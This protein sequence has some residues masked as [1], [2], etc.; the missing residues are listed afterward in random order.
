MINKPPIYIPIKHICSL[1]NKYYWNDWDPYEFVGEIN[2]DLVDQLS[3]LSYRAVVT[4]AIGCTEWVIWRFRDKLKDETPY[5]YIEACWLYNITDK[6]E[7]PPELED[8][9]W[10]GEVRGAVN[11]ALSTV[12][13]SIYSIEDECPE[14]EAAYADK[15]AL[16]VFGEDELYIRWRDKVLSRLSEFYPRD[17]KNPLGKPIARE[18]LNPDEKYLYEFSDDLISKFI[19]TIDIKNNQFI[20][21]F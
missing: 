13:N 10:K 20:Q 18:I 6:Y 5:K 19:S 8:E 9:E 1:S 12:L 11:L 7:T 2:E 15:V 17:T 21:I 14:A 4:F 16:Y 3:K